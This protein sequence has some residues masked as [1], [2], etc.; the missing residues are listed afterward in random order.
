[1]SIDSLADTKVAHMED[2]NLRTWK[3]YKD[4]FGL[5]CKFYTNLSVI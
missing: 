2:I 1:M 4:S 3:V 5:V